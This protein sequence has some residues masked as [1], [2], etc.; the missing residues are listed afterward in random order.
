MV[1][2]KTEWLSLRLHSEEIFNLVSKLNVLDQVDSE[3]QLV[4]ELHSEL[5]CMNILIL[6]LRGQILASPKV[7]TVQG[8]HS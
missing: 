8:C 7:N 5:S 1:V 4:L 3:A 2:T 6:Q